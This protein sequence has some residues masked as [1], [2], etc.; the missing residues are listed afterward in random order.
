MIGYIYHIVCK[1][2]DKHYIG[3]TANLSERIYKHFHQ[4]KKQTHENFKLQKDYNQYGEESFYYY[5]QEYEVKD[6]NELGM[7]E[8]EEIKKYNSIENGYNIAS[9]GQVG[10]KYNINGLSK[11]QVFMILSQQFD[12]GNR[13]IPY[14][15]EKC[16]CHTDSIQK[17]FSNKSFKELHDEYN[18]LSK[19]DKQYWLN[20]SR[21]YFNIDLKYFKNSFYTKRDFCAVR[22]LI[23][24]TDYKKTTIAQTLGISVSTILRF[25]N[26]EVNQDYG[27]YYESLNDNSRRLFAE[28]IQKEYDFKGVSNIRKK[29]NGAPRFSKEEIFEILDRVLNKKQT[30]QSIAD[31]KA[32]DRTV[33]YRICNG[34][35]YVNYYNEF[36][37]ASNR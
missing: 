6:R 5:Y 17:V 34:K 20:K 21:E 29:L 31:E 12:N 7:I 28:E 13:N 33:I 9:G 37:N 11:Q 8:I 2:N 1:N 22:S 18:M 27:L 4:L 30:R 32:V 23:E 26:N 15:A 36:M 19:E 35:S 3:M 25:Y 14:L 24:F 10:C 16:K